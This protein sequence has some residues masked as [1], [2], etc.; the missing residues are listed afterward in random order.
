[1]RGEGVAIYMLKTYALTGFCLEFLRAEGGVAILEQGAGRS[2]FPAQVVLWLEEDL[3]GALRNLAT[4]AEGE[5]IS[6]PVRLRP[7]AAL[8]ARSAELDLPELFE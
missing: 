7:G 5:P 2:A 8:A 3:V 4:A 1:M 6:G